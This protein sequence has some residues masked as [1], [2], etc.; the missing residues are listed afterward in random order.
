VD[1]KGK[2]VP[3]VDLQSSTQTDE[4]KKSL[5]RILSK[6]PKNR[7]PNA[8]GKLKERRFQTKYGFCD[9]SNLNS[10]SSRQNST[11][12]KKTP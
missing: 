12:R 6:T 10:D 9:I 1:L 5:N 11:H 8:C 2:K 7:S 4:E 3:V